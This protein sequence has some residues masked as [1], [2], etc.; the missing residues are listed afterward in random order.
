MRGQRLVKRKQLQR[1][2]KFWV[3]KKKPTGLMVF[4]RVPLSYEMMP[5]SLVSDP[6]CSKI[7]YTSAHNLTN[8]HLS[9]HLFRGLKKHTHTNIL[10]LNCYSDSQ[11]SDRPF[12]TVFFTATKPPIG[13][14]L[15][16]I[17]VVIDLALY[18]TLPFFSF[19]Q[20]TENPFW[21]L[22]GKEEL[23][24][25]AGTG[26]TLGLLERTTSSPM[27]SNQRQ[28]NLFSIIVIIVVIG[29]SCFFSYKVWFFLL[30]IV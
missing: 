18:F 8:C 21:R 20:T 25:N 19:V 30:G 12:V 6:T 29:S 16:N 1:D 3:V 26:R 23:R 10:T 27:S 2:I 4:Q 11:I 5:N 9:L 22:R 28:G 7:M 24:K 13:L 14:W 15:R 17:T